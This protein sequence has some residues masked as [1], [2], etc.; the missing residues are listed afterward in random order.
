MKVIPLKS[1]SA[2]ILAGQVKHG[3]L[4]SIS[5]ALEGV[6][7]ELVNCYHHIRLA[8]RGW[9]LG[10]YPIYPLSR[11]SPKHLWYVVLEAILE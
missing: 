2:V 11:S 9:K 4:P 1:N 6:I 8:N 7:S 10:L 5:Q 3:N